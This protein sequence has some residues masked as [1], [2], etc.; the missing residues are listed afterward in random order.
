MLL[1]EFF[2]GAH[3]AIPVANRLLRALSPDDLDPLRA[4]LETVPLPQKQTLSS[5]GTSIDHVYFPQEGM[6]SLVQPLEDVATIEVGMIGNEGLVG[7]PVLLGADSSP[8]RSDGPDSRVC[9]ANAGKRFR[10]EVGHRAGFLGVLLRYA[11][12]LHV[13][14]SL[15]A[16]C[17]GRHT[18]PER[19]ARWLLTAHD[20][21]PNDQLPLSHEFLSQMLGVRRAGVTVALGTLK[22]A[23]LIRNSHAQVHI[24]D[25]LGLE[26][27]SCDCYSTVRDEYARLLS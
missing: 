20:R 12:A 7:T 16:A 23:G 14:V 13:Q 5:P 10:E 11:Q 17:N 4:H 9:L 25:R 26:A 18:V 2:G 22:V 3:A 24:I 1:L 15:T 6:V 27:A 21:S 8:S 19:L